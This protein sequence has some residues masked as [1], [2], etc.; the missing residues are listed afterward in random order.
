MHVVIVG[1]FNFLRKVSRPDERG[2]SVRIG[3]DGTQTDEFASGEFNVLVCPSY[4]IKVQNSSVR[5]GTAT[6]HTPRYRGADD[7]QGISLSSTT[8]T[9]RPPYL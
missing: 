7:G 3:T 5:R 2:L 8:P 6:T 4:S 1:E 9:S